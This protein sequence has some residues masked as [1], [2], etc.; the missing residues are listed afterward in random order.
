MGP[1]GCLTWRVTACTLKQLVKVFK[2]EKQHLIHPG[3]LVRG[4]NLPKQTVQQE[5]VHL[6]EIKHK[7]KTDFIDRFLMKLTL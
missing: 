6:G 4:Q 7:S 3:H 2:I 5:E 1:T